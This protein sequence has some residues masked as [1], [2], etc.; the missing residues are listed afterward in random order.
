MLGK[1]NNDHAPVLI[2]RQQ[3]E[4]VVLMSLKDFPDLEETAYL[5]RSSENSRRLKDARSAKPMPRHYPVKYPTWL[6]S[7]HTRVEI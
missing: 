3:G 2:T 6:N 4:C 7:R 5:L 1:V